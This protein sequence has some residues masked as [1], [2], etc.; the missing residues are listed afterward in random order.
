MTPVQPRK[1]SI[2]TVVL[3]A[4]VAVAAAGEFWFA[5]EMAIHIL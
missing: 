3:I 5:I 1:L 2:T 4:L